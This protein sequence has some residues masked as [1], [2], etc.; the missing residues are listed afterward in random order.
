MKEESQTGVQ[1]F[2]LLFILNKKVIRFV[3]VSQKW[4][5]KFQWKRSNKISQFSKSI[6]KLK[7][8]KTINL[9]SFKTDLR[10]GSASNRMNLHNYKVICYQNRCSLCIV[11]STFLYFLIMSLVREETMLRISSWNC[12]ENLCFL[13]APRV[14]VVAKCSTIAWLSKNVVSE[15]REIS[16]YAFHIL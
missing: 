13:G 2:C 11:Y 9:I 16:D 3:F 7:K 14:P 10:S 5:I 8:E 15:N 12:S 4:S 6:D 1:L